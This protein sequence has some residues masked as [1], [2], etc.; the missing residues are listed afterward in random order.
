[1]RRRAVQVFRNSARRSVDSG[2][3]VGCA[4]IAGFMH[5]GNMGV[6][7]NRLPSNLMIF[8]LGLALL[9]M[10]SSVRVFGADR[11]VFWRESSS[12]VSVAAFFFGRVVVSFVDLA[13]QCVL[14]VSI[15]FLICHP[16]HP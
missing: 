9:T 16:T 7:S 12:G 11:P 15:Y 5:R 2:L 6:D 1:M 10:V 8:H 14:Y 13:F 3:V 4:L